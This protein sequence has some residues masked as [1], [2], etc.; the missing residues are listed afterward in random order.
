[1]ISFML[2]KWFYDLWD[3]MLVLALVNIGF[4]VSLAIPLMA[5]SALSSVP[6][7]SYILAFAGLLWC[8]TYMNA[9]A[10]MMR[11]LTDGGGFTA[12]EFIG[13]IKSSWRSGAVLGVIAIA[14]AYCILVAI[15]FY[16]GSGSTLGLVA[17][18]TLFWMILLLLFAMQFFPALRARNPGTPKITARKCLELFFDNPI[19]S[20][21]TALLNTILMAVSFFVAF[22]LP[23]P[24]GCLL[25][26]DEAVRLR[27][28]KYDY[29]AANPTADRK[30][31]PWGELLAEEKELTGTRTLK[32]LIFPW[33][34]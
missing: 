33:K 2:K 5:P 28:M 24:S 14:L 1:M 32:N 6:V 4:L 19:F 22:M 13:A 30:R 20:I 25:L 7:L 17:G 9:A 34:G 31:I 21:M 11:I 27:T 26:L 23:G 8:S 3:H 10:M 16:I 18:A 12:R 29:L 15:P